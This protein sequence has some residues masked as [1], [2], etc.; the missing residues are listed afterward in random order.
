MM[1]WKKGLIGIIFLDLSIEKLGLLEVLT[2][3]NFKCV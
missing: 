1:G 2:K 3:Q